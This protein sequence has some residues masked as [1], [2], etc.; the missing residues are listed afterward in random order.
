[1]RKRVVRRGLT[2]LVVGSVGIEVVHA[3]HLVKSPPQFLYNPH[4]FQFSLSRDESRADIDVDYRSSRFPV[5]LFNG[6]LTASNSDI[7]A[8]GNDAKHN[9]QPRRPAPRQC[10]PRLPASVRN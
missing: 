4:L 10:A 5:A 8:S 1:V 9:Q 6:H 7:R 2:F 3:L